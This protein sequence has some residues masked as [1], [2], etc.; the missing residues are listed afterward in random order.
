MYEVIDI[1][2][3]GRA[4]F[5]IR[6]IGGEVIETFQSKREARRRAKHINA[7]LNRKANGETKKRNRLKKG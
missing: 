1:S 5:G 7:L 6:L 2:H 3:T 4:N